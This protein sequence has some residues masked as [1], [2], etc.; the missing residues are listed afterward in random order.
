MR[1]PDHRADPAALHDVVVVGAGPAGRALA[2][3]CASRGLHTALVDPTPER[4]WRI[5]YGA[6]TAELPTDLPASAIAARARG[7]AVA[8][9]PWELGWEYTVIDVPGLRAHLDAGLAGVT[10]VPGRVVQRDADGVALADGTRMPARAVV[11]AGGYRQPLLPRPPDQR[12]R[13]RAD[14]LRA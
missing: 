3:A 5:T 12:A 9:S 6:F 13:G 14:R 1:S 11:D 8:L 2:G 4:A 10:V 7:R